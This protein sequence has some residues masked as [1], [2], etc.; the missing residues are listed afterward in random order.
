VSDS[1]APAD[2][3]TAAPPEPDDVDRSV[4]QDL[5]NGPSTKDEE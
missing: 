1:A 2:E 5:T 4:L 3:S